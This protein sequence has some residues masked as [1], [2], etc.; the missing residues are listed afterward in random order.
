MKKMLLVLLLAALSASAHA[1]WTRIEY[2]SKAFVL[3]VENDPLVKQ[4]P[5]SVKLWH[6]MDFGEAQ[7]LDGRP[8]LS[9]KA[10]D[11]YDCGRGMRRDLM[12][13]WHF[14]NM[15][16]GTLLKAAYKP[17]SWSAPAAGSVEEALMRLV[18]PKN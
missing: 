13:L 9:I 15:A 7:S 16:D 17:G 12:H 10:R 3:S 18:C 5:N 1:E 11:E 4:D 2:P 8:F 14:G 6:L